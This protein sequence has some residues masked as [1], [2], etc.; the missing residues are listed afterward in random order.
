MAVCVGEA[1]TRSPAVA[2]MALVADAMG[3]G[4]TVTP[5]AVIGATG[6]TAGAGL[7]SGTVLDTES[8]STASGVAGFGVSADGVG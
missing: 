4:A 7:A 6:R 2:A 1:D 8:V 3:G 5:V